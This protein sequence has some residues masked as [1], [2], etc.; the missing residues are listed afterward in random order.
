MRPKKGHQQKEGTCPK[1]SI[2]THLG[3]DE[4]S[5]GPQ[6]EQKEAN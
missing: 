5:W 3:M 1:S 6:V 2:K 4:M